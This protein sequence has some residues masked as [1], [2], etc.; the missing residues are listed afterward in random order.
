MG[1]DDWVEDKVG[2]RVEDSALVRGNGNS[3]GGGIG[4][5]LAAPFCFVGV[6]AIVD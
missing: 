4:R 5:M 2:G 6:G 1:D 3:R